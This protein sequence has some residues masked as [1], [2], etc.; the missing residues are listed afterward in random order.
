ML[1][2]QYEKFKNTV[3]SILVAYFCF[4]KMLVTIDISEFEQC[5]KTFSCLY[6]DYL[7]IRLVKIVNLWYNLDCKS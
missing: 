1:I 4:F 7:S 6:P 3:F 5:K 2:F